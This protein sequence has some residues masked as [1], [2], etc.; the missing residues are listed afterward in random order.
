MVTRSVKQPRSECPPTVRTIVRAWH[1]DRSISESSARQYL[2]WISRFRRYCAQLG[3]SE[4]DELTYEGARR[5]RVWC[6]RTR[7]SEEGH[8]GNVSSSLRALRR[9]YEVM[10]MQVPPW[11]PVKPSS[12]VHRP[13]R[14]SCA[15]TPRI[16]LSIEATQKPRSARSSTMSDSGMALSLYS[17]T[18]Y[19]TRRC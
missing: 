10:G 18:R 15:T 2:G 5:F 3:L 1:A 19:R 11:Q 8:I 7:R 6:A 16:S 4:L 9:V 14:S 12:A 13:P 17:T